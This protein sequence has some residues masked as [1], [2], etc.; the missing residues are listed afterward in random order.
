MAFPQFDENMT[1]DVPRDLNALAAAVEEAL[2]THESDAVKHITA[3][4]REKWNAVKT[5]LEQHVAD[6]VKHITAA[7]R[8]AWNAKET[9]TGAQTKATKAYNDAVS[10]VD[11][12]YIKKAILIPA[13]ANLND[14]I[15]EGEYYCPANATAQ[16]IANVPLLNSAFSLKV[17]KHAGVV[18]IFT[19]YAAQDPRIYIRNYY[20]SWSPWHEVYTTYSKPL[21]RNIY[22]SSASPSGGSDGDVWIQY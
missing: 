12:N 5:S 16:T 8:T 18:Q 13:S 15:Y 4:E 22:I 6:A 10:H 7:E 21:H 1:A 3:E 11:V 20:S 17:L 9:T 19:N 14:Y 2:G